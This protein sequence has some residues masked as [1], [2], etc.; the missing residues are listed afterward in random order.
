MSSCPCRGGTCA[1]LGWCPKGARPSLWLT[2][3]FLPCVRGAGMWRAGMLALVAPELG[4]P[5]PSF[6]RA[7][8]SPKAQWQAA[9][10]GWLA[11]RHQRQARTC[12]AAFR[13]LG[14]LG[15]TSS[16]R[17]PKAARQVWEG[18]NSR[19]IRGTGR[20]R[21]SLRGSTSVKSWWEA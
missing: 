2:T 20:E 7:A 18:G 10:L 21:K 1:L 17:G 19:P 9:L 16:T 4:V 5:L 8:R 12:L 3:T 6:A 14:C 11:T 13:Q 15:S